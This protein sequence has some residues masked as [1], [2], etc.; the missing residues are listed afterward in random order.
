MKN[1]LFLAAIGA[2]L[3]TL[4]ACNARDASAEAGP[5]EE[6]ITYPITGTIVSR[7]EAKNQLRTD[8]DEIPGFMDA[9]K[10]NYE[11]RGARVSALPANGSRFRGTLHVSDN[12]Y[13]LTDVVAE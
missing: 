9:M 4:A 7:V 10:M 11:V 3:L 6:V 2:I 1:V 8:H 5:A 13:W 12:G